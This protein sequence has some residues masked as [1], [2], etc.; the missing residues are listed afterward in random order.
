MGRSNR[1]IRRDSSDESDCTSSG[2]DVRLDINFRRCDV[3][4]GNVAVTGWGA[5]VTLSGTAITCDDIPDDAPRV[6]FITAMPKQR[7]I[8]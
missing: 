7:W 4:L 6:A 5:A 2:F 1:W 3:T 8:A